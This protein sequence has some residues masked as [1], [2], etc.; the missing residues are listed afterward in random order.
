LCPTVGD[1]VTSLSDSSS[2]NLHHMAS[3]DKDNTLHLG[4]KKNLNEKIFIDI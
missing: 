2:I 4:N 3:I 1:H